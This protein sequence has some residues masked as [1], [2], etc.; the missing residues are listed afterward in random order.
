MRPTSGGHS[1]IGIPLAASFVEAFEKAYDYK[2]KW[3]ANAAYLQVA[4]WANAIE[5][6]GTF[7][8]PEVIRT[9]EEGGPMESTVGPVRFSRSGPSSIAREAPAG[10][11]R[12]H[13]D[14]AQR[15]IRSLANYLFQLRRLGE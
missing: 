1:R 13:A 4:F 2:P 12:W 5:T 3:G 8:P 11:Q 6:A 10:N 7:Y 14:R 15:N 9:Y